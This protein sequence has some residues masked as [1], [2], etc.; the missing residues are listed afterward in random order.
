[1]VRGIIY[2][3]TQE[4]GANY[5]G[6]TFRTISIRFSEHKRWAKYGIWNS[7]SCK[8]LFDDKY[9]NDP[10]IE[11][12]DYIDFKD[13]NDKNKNVLRTIEF[14]HIQNSVNNINK[15]KKL[16]DPDTWYAKNKQQIKQKRNKKMITCECGQEIN[17]YRR[18]RHY[19]TKKHNK[20]V[21]G[22]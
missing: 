11:E 8:A 7:S 1:M 5:I 13:C 22:V 18:S 2:K 14:Y 9:Q 19:K 20:I 17:Y 16:G 6:S 12:I 3:V 21:N 15:I 4:D 10:I